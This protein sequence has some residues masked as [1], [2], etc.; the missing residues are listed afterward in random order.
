MRRAALAAALLAASPALAAPA[1]KVEVRYTA[2]GVAHVKATDMFGV[3]YGYGWAFARDNLCLAVDHAITLAGERAARLGADKSYF[4]GFANL[5]GGATVPNLD[6]DAFYRAHLGPDVLAAAQ[7]T[8]SADVRAV[9]RGYAAGFAAHANGPALPGEECR[10][11]PGYRSITEAD[12]WRR[13]IEIA[14]LETSNLLLLQITGATPPGASGTAPAPI[15]F[16]GPTDE[17][18]A[19]SNAAAFGRKLVTGGGGMSFSN[20]HFP[21]SGIERLHAV[22]LTVPGKLDVFGSALYNFPLPMLGFNRSFGWSITYTT[23]RHA[24]LYRLDLDPKDPTRYR[25]GARFER[26]QPVSVKVPTGHGTLARTLWETRYGFVAAG[27]AMP[28]TREHAY[29]L[30][31]PERRNYRIADQFLALDRALDVREAKAAMDRWMGLPW[32]NVTAAD[33]KGDVIFANISLTPD[34]DD[35]KFARCRIELPGAPAGLSE[36]VAVMDGSNPDC[37]WTR[38]PA[39]VQSGT[40]PPARRPWTIRDDFVLNSNDSHWLASWDDARLSGFAKT[41]GDEATL[42]GERTR[43]GIMMARGRRDGTDG[44]GGPGID[45]GKWE[46]LFFRSRNL[47]AELLLD[48]VL[49]DCRARPVVDLGAEEKVDLGLA[50]ATLGRWDRTDRLDARGATLFREFLNMLE[51]QPATGLKLADRYWR[52]P[53]DTAD[54]VGTPRGL[55]VSDETRIAL[56]RALLNMGKAALPVDQP[57][58]EAQ[59]AERNGTLLPMSGSRYSYNL[60]GGRLVPGKGIGPVIGGDSYMHIV[61]WDAAG[62]HGRFLVTYSQSTNPASPHFGDMTALF[63]T[64]SLADIAFDDAAIAAAQVGPTVTLDP[65][66]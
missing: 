23:D 54:P 37:A 15:A 38:D 65:G 56:A 62:P 59:F 10:A 47:M 60:I 9:M 18:R 3:G 50:C 46:A 24:T 58:R 28:W 7:H 34:I 64:Q 27:P 4:D 40:V 53:F 30:A 14:F 33:A 29:T 8:A 49:A 41:I 13:A 16:T 36:L 52:V 17:T 66:R 20:P 39:A 25:I 19:G 11:K 43:M 32:S 35:A 44:L 61:G 22:H 1:A 57:L 63:S 48:D 42:R 21:W 6:S 55:K 12:L 51:H 31:D 26:M 2:Y 5:E 45:P